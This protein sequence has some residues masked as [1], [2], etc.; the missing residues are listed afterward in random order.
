M[1]PLSL[2][3]QLLN[4]SFS[5]Q[6][7]A[8]E[9]VLEV[10]DIIGEDCFGQGICAKQVSEAIAAAGNF[11]RVTLSIN[12]PGGDLFEG[13]AIYN[14]LKGCGKP[15]SAKVIGLAASAASLI[16]CAGDEVTMGL[17]TQYMLHEAMAIE[18]GYA[19]DMRKMADTLDS[20]TNSAADIYVAKTGMAKDKILAMMAAE[21]WM[22]S[23]EAC[24]KGFAD[25]CSK[26]QAMASTRS[27]DLSVFKNAPAEL[28]KTE[29][30]PKTEP[31]VAP[32]PIVEAEAD[33]LIDIYRK[34]IAVARS[35]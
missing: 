5:A 3:K 10:Y 20:V 18:A 16:A 14:I 13:V 25:A 35:K 7:N 32:A 30:E 27:F 12:S 1:K 31:E 19:A 2:R 33:P 15:V 6:A 8:G 29:P 23:E 28:S 24:T 17:G 11:D 22:G 34:R 21:T 9:L 26:T 4:T